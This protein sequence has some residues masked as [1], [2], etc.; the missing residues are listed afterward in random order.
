MSSKNVFRYLSALINTVY[1]NLKVFPFKT[2]VKLPCYLGSHV[3]YNNLYKNTVRINGEIKRGMICL[4]TDRG[5][6][7]VECN[8][9]SYWS[10]DKNC[11]VIF[12]GKIRLAQGCSLRCDKD[13]TIEFGK[14]VSFNQNFFCASNSTVKFGDDVLGGWNISVR[15]CEGHPVYD[16]ISGEKKV[17]IKPVTIGNHVWIGTESKIL[18]GTYIDDGSIVGLGSV[19]T[20]NYSGKRNIVVAGNPAAIVKENVSWE[21]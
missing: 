21:H 2:A 7:G 12:N 8:K 1:F 16:I 11:N 18:K 15:D 10:V 14:N 13:G 19:L 17:N 5:S 3:R 6:F 9:Y 20:K 4:G